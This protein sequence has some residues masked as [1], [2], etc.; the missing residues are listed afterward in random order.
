MAVSTPEA[1]TLDLIR[2]GSIIPMGRGSETF[3]SP[4]KGARKND[5]WQLLINATVEGD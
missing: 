4:A 5:R 3:A 1:T 2:S